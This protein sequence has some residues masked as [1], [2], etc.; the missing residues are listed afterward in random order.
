MWVR[1]GRCGC[2]FTWFC[3]HLIAKP[4][5][6]T[7]A[8]SWPDP[9]HGT[10]DPLQNLN[11]KQLNLNKINL[12]NISSSIYLDDSYHG[13]QCYFKHFQA[14]LQENTLFSRQNWGSIISQGS[15]QIQTIFKAR[16]KLG[17]RLLPWLY[18]AWNRNSIIPKSHQGHSITQGPIL[19]RKKTKVKLNNHWHSTAV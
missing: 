9:C 5:N 3:Y 6:K 2:L 17:I 4:G 8:P 12:V 19:L 14:F 15:S 16:I 11:I 7:A 1:S 10:Y 18:E 13:F